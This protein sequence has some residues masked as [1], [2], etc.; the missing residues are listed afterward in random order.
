MIAAASNIGLSS[1]SNEFDT[2]YKSLSL[3]DYMILGILFILGL[4]LFFYLFFR[5]TPNFDH[6]YGGNISGFNVEDD[7]SLT[8]KTTF[9]TVPKTLTQSP[10]LKDNCFKLI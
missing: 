6:R 8:P 7:G 5:S 9:E 3:I 1:F 4:L 2:Q 10:S